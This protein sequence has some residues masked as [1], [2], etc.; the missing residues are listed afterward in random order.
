MYFRLL[1]TLLISP[2]RSSVPPLGPC[3]TPFR[4]LPTDLDLLFHMNNA[5]YF[6]LMDLA[7]VDLM[8]RS[9]L[10]KV[11]SRNQWYPV[12]I[13]ETA[14]FKKSIA[15]FQSF[16]IE[17]KILGWDEK[18]VLLEQTFVSGKTIHCQAVVRALFLRKARET[19]SLRIS[20][21]G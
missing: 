3:I 11:F 1:W 13:A 19:N 8:K 2:F 6:S 12:V 7:R 9:G 16:D 5:K 14:Q 17:T 10:L 20:P 18:A 21:T 15:L 4:C